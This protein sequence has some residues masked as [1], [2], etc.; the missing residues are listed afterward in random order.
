MSANVRARGWASLVVLVASLAGAR[1]AHAN[2]AAPADIPPPK[3]EGVP[4]EVKL[5]KGE[6]PL[7]L[8]IPRELLPQDRKAAG[9]LRGVDDIRTFVAGLAISLALIVCGLVVA[10]KFGAAGAKPLP[11]AATAGM[12]VAL[13]ACGAAVAWANAPP[14]ALVKKLQEER[15]LK[16][17][18]VIVD[19][20]DKVVLR[21]SSEHFEKISLAL[22]AQ[23]ESAGA[24][25]RTSAAPPG[26]SK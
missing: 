4:F 1:I 13:L 7:R 20:G 22:D 16:L 8:E 12:M 15:K 10:R 5:Q 23:A 26:G 3:R 24:S 25:S 11:K 21:G 19:G 6:L 14:P 18:I 9:V 2:K 17:E